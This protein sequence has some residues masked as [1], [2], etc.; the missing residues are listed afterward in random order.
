MEHFDEIEVERLNIVGPDGT[1][2]FVLANEARLPSP[3]LGGKEVG[4][5]DGVHGP[6]FVFYNELGDECGGFSFHAEDEDGRTK[7]RSML[8]LD[9]FRNNEVL[10]ILYDHSEGTHTYGI[11]AQEPLALPI[12]EALER[13]R[14]ISE[15][16]DETAK[17]QAEKQLYKDFEQHQR[18]F[19]GRTSDGAATVSLSLSD[20]QG[21]PRLRMLV[22]TDGDPRIE[23]LDEHGEVTHRFPPTD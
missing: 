5:R 15:L 22:G 8:L 10:G 21:R 18:L 7:A 17:A 2:R 14:E 6:L 3:I 12:S 13:Q 16:P 4:N 1:P 23:F 11:V 19:V 9:Q 20:G